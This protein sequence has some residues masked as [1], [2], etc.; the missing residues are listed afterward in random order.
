MYKTPLQIQ[1]QFLD[2]DFS[3]RWDRSR[4]V[5]WHGEGIHTFIVRVR[6]KATE[7][8]GLLRSQ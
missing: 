7:F 5:S 8:Y 6:T 2:T 4:N 1:V 3:I